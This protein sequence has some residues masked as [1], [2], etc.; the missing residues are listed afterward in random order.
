MEPPEPLPAPGKIAHHGYEYADCALLIFASP[1]NPAPAAK[2]AMISMRVIISLPLVVSACP[3]YGRG[4]AFCSVSERR[5][6]EFTSDIASELPGV[7][8][9]TRQGL[10]CD[11]S[12][13]REAVRIS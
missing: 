12:R 9:W 13:A 4:V 5:Q 10:N 1:I 3:S 11:P 6:A 8:W 2:S 7:S